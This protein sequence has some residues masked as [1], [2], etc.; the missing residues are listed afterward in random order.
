M[1]TSPS[2]SLGSLNGQIYMKETTI[3]LTLLVPKFNNLY[4]VDFLQSVVWDEFRT[5]RGKEKIKK[6]R[7]MRQYIKIVL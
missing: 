7:V 1:R 3:T 5:L 6:V 4:A 2:M